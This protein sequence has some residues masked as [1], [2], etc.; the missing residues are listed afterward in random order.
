MQSKTDTK[1][2]SDWCKMLN[3]NFV[4]RTD[5]K[6]PLEIIRDFKLIRTLKKIK[7]DVILFNTMTL[8][9]TLFAKCFLKNFLIIVHDVEYHPHSKDFYSLITLKLVYKLHLKRICTASKTQSELFKQ[10]YGF[11]PKLLPFPVTEYFYDMSSD[12]NINLRKNYTQ[13]G[14]KVKFLFFGTIE[15]YKGI[16]N[17]LNAAKILYNKNIPFELKICGKINYNEEEIIKQC[18]EIPS[19]TLSNKYI[20]YNNIHQLFC[21]NDVLILPYK[22][23]TQCGPLMIAYKEYMPVIVSELAGFREFVD[24]GCSGLFFDNTPKDLAEQMKV[25]IEDSQLIEKMKIY[26]KENIQKRFSIF[27]LSND[28]INELK[29]S[30]K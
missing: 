6:N 17:L 1:E 12:K 27:N 29:K 20:E 15:S 26:I 28:Y 21:E 3:A 13:R 4:K 9:Q 23:V 2:L 24:E 7:G 11:Y 19:I 30:V 10:K 25:F 8:Y 14:E 18:N 5:Y 16:E 22:Q